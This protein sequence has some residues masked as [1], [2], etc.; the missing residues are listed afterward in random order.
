MTENNKYI[1]GDCL[2][3]MKNISD[4]SIDMILADPPQ[5]I[6]QNKWD[7]IIPLSE[8]WK[9]I[10][11][12]IKDNGAIILF[13]NQ[14][15]TSELIMSNKKMFRYTMVWYKTTSTGF[16]NA[17]KQPLRIHE[18]IVVFYKKPPAYNPQMSTGHKP[19]N[20][21]TKYTGDGNNYGIT[22]IGISGGGSTKRYPTTVIRFPTDKQK[23][24]LHST[25]K[26]IAML[27]YLI[28]TFSNPGDTILDISAGVGSTH[29][30][31][32]ETDRKS[33]SIEKD[34]EIWKLGNT[35]IHS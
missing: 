19:V 20:S 12:I 18:D 21:Y 3:I 17:K 10:N 5:G 27:K 33:I 6:T 24:A 4:K 35:R 9:G 15:Y 14:P 1:N 25:Q 13:A 8:M 7:I 34:I 30:A 28:R 29:I 11:R 2:D 16:L 31:A 32:V 26:P 22:K 23:S